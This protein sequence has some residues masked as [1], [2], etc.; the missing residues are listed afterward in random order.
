MTNLYFP[1]TLLK[2]H[3]MKNRENEGLDLFSQG[4]TNVIG[5]ILPK[6]SPLLP[7]LE[8]T[9]FQMFEQG[10][11]SQL[12]QNYLW[13]PS[14]ALTS[15]DTLM[16]VSV[17]QTVLAIATIAGGSVLALTIFCIEIIASA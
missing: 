1:D 17:G 7:I 2:Y 6:N 14:K 12:R 5:I 3:F 8:P 13:S 4:R 11:T 16:P 9:A 10:I 15:Q